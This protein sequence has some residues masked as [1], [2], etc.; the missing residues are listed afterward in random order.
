MAILDELADAGCLFLALTGGDP[1]MRK[2][3]FDIIEAACDRSFAV[4]LQTN[5]T[6]LKKKDIERMGRLKTLRVDVSVYGARPETHDY[7][8][9]VPGSF[10]G[11]M[12]SLELLKENG[13]PIIFKVIV[14]GFNLD[15]VEE[16]AALADGLETPAIFTSLIFPKNDRDRGP[17]RLRLD[18]AGLERFMRFELQYLPPYLS[19]ISGSEVHDVA[20]YIQKC[21]I[22]PQDPEGGERRYCGA[23]R[24]VFAINP[25]GDLYPCVAFPLKVANVRKGSLL[26]A[27]RTAPLLKQ[28]RATEAELPEQCENCELLDRCGIC[29][30]LAYQEEGRVLAVSPEKCRMT[31]TLA[32]VI[33]S[34]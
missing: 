22:G 31:R 3:L 30:A 26:E 34:P 7:M 6:L 17:T 28:L 12:R 27:W 25:Y 29:R 24:T 23:A 20:E 19:E 18:D 14:C 21:A 33:E 32:R 9:R 15:E 1:T 2:D 8:T 16:I 11:T 10:A 13:V 4:T 5:A